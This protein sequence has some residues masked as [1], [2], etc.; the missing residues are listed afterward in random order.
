MK[1]YRN[2]LKNNYYKNYKFYFFNR[3]ELKYYLYCKLLQ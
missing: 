3:I 1:Y 2:K